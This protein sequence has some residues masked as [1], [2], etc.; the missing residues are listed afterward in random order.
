MPPTWLNFKDLKKEYD[1]SV[2][3]RAAG[4]LSVLSFRSGPGEILEKMRE[5]GSEAFAEY[6]EKM[7]AE[8][9][10][11]EEKLSGRAMQ[12]KKKCK[13][14]GGKCRKCGSCRSGIGRICG[15]CWRM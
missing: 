2:P 3:A 4:Y 10:R 7:D 1:V 8:R 11:L 5:L 6:I 13:A 14:A 12:G 9:R 15:Q